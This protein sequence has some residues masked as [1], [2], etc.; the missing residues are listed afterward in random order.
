LLGLARSALLKQPL[1]RFIVAED[2]DSYYRHRKH[3]FETG[4]PQAYELRL[5]HAEAAPFWAQVEAT[6]TPPAASTAGQAAG[7]A[8]MCRVVFSDI[9][10][11]KEVEATLLAERASLT[12]RVEART[13]ELS[14]RT[15]ELSAANQR[16]RQL[17]R[18]IVMAHDE[19][20][21]HLARELHDE[22]GQ[23]LTGLKF[24]LETGQRLPLEGM[25]A[26]QQQ[27]LGLVGELMQQVHNLSLDLHPVI[28]DDFGLLPTLLWHIGRYTA[29]TKIQVNFEH[30]GLEQRFAAEIETAAYRIVQEALTNIARHSGAS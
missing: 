25:Q 30:A 15:A 5:T 11:R 1:T 17:T 26:T 16:L 9:T 22:A 29:Q 18:Q 2:Q 13:A 7:G 19:E 28:L 8:P 27:A 12:Q 10:A 14:A 24:T 23:M 20:R 3:L 4:V 21:R 6:L